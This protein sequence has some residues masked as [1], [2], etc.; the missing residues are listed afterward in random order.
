[1]SRPIRQ[2]LPVWC[3]PAAQAAALVY[4]SVVRARNARLERGHGVRKVDRPVISVGNIVAGGTGKSPF[5]RW[6]AKWAVDHGL[7]PMIAMR[8]Y[9]AKHGRSDEAD[10]HRLLM[11]DVVLAVGADRYAKISAALT[12]RPGVGA[13]I[14]DDGFQHRQIARDLDLVLIDA[15]RSELDGRLLPHGWL[16]E[17]ASGLRRAHGIIITRARGFD[18]TLASAVEAKHGRPPVAWC[19]HRWSQLC[20]HRAPHR[21]EAQTEQVSPE[22]LKGVRVAVW[23]GIAHPQPFVDQVTQAGA[24]V[25]SMPRRSDHARYSRQTIAKLA[26]DAQAEGAQAVVMPGKDWVKVATDMDVIGMPVVVPQLELHFIYGEEALGEL[27]RNAIK[28]R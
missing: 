28:C 14:L 6:V 11:P 22:W 7:A 9:R 18:Q 19:D 3:A 26:A 13:V 10:E 24:I 5:V 21:G 8:G 25:V 27:L 2:P 20:I 12:N 1:M 17:P 15:A 23:A 16:R 4:G